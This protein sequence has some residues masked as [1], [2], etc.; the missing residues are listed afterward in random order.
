MTTMDLILYVLA[1]IV[2]SLG[3]GRIV[4]LVT[5]DA[6]PPA[7]W[8][9]VRWNVWVGE[10]WG[11]LAECPWCAAPYVV[12]ANTAWALLSD[13]HASWWVANIIAAGAYVASWVVIHDED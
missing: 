13:F 5:Q 12:A 7:E 1:F 6:F 11:V 4:R 2:G 8:L 10:K 3:S 9:R